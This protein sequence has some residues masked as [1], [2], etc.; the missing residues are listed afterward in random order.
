MTFGVAFGVI[1]LI[2]STV[3]LFWEAA[4]AFHLYSWSFGLKDILFSSFWGTYP[5]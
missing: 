5:V 4:A 3:M 2:G 1:F